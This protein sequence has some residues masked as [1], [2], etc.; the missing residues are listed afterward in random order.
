MPFK[1]AAEKRAYQREYMRRKRA[2]QEPDPGNVRPD[3][4]PA[5]ESVSPDQD[6]EA[7]PEA[8]EARRRYQREYW[9]RNPDKRR[10]K[11]ARAEYRRATGHP[12]GEPMPPRED[13]TP[14]AREAARRYNRAHKARYWARRAERER[15]LGIVPE[16]SRPQPVRKPARELTPA[17]LEAGREAQRRWQREYKRE[18][19]RRNPE[20]RA[21]HLA[22]YWHKQATG[23]PGPADGAW[24]PEAR[25]AKAAYDAKYTR[26]YLQRHPEKRREYARRYWAHRAE[27]EAAARRIDRGENREKRG[28]F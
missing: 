23:E 26:G 3:V 12:A 19:Y 1:S 27:R 14:E 8:L 4:R 15:A 22:R 7:A 2:G 6:Q 5:P 16:A 13:W 10:E 18:Y 11:E 25:A 21:A 17:E 28:R 24:T 9:R 20:K